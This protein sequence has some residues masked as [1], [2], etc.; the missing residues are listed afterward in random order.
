[1]A[2]A[3]A[4]GP[5]RPSGAALAAARAWME[6]PV[7][8]CG[9]HRSG[10]TL[11]RAL[12]DGHPEVRV[13]PSEG[14]FR[15]SFPDAAVARPTDAALDRF[16]A[17]WVSRLVDPNAEPHFKLGRSAAND[18]PAV[19]FVR[20]LFGWHDA[21]REEPVPEARAPWRAFLALVA[22]FRED[23]APRLWAEKTPRNE[24]EAGA[25][26]RAFPEARFVHLVREPGATLASLL[27]I[28][29]RAGLGDADRAL[30]ARDIARSFGLALSN[31]RRLGDR[32][33]V[34][35]FEDLVSRPDRAV[36]RVA[37]FLG[38][39]PDD[40]L[41]TPT[42]MG[43]PVRPNSAFGAGEPGRIREPRRSAGPPGEEREVVAL[44]ASR[45]ARVLGYDVPP[46]PWRRR[47]P[48][49]FREAR[50]Y[51]VGRLGASEKTSNRP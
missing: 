16:A 42:E 40:V 44:F 18:L 21:L 20:R 25:L 37:T 3:R 50:R 13:L 12:L 9:H 10:T 5:A 27:E 24:R 43:R 8:L 48:V 15:T 26:L 38:I 32:Y 33:L 2:A 46:L 19:S 39:A 47:A 6:R 23:G 36:E 29:R 41:A 22:A 34:L 14:T 7:F 45:L 28:R 30:R 17:E 51:F 49:L 1:M 35:R 11:V 4:D 31:P